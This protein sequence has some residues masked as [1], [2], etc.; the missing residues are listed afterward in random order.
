MLKVAH[1]LGATATLAKP[2]AP[3][4]F[5]KTVCAMLEARV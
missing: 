2:S 4:H 1:L 3:A 5:L